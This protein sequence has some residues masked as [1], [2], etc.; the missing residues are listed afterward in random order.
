MIDNKEA[1]LQ[2]ATV[3]F[4]K[5]FADTD[6]GTGTGI[7]SNSENQ[8][9]GEDL[10]KKII[11]KFRKCKVYSFRDNIWDVH[12]ADMQLMT[13]Y[14]RGTRFLLCVINIYS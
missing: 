11:R 4:D 3:F 14:N 1:L 9:L 8:K 5:T 13:K 7:N 6:I 12:L 2:W 10:H